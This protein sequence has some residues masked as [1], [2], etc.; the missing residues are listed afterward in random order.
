MNG[1]AFLA[2]VL[3]FLVP[4]LAP[5]D[6][7][8][9]DNLSSHKVAGV[10][11]AIGRAGAALQCLVGVFSAASCFLARWVARSIR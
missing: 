5:G 9:M 7:V 10:G 4:T 8:V 1:E 6:V 11:A 2:Y 3:D